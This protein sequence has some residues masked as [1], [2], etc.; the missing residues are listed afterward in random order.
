M[1][2]R[3]SILGDG[4]WGTALSIVLSDHGADVLLW[5]HDPDY[6]AEMEQSRRNPKFLPGVEIPD[7]VR[8]SSSLKDAVA[9][10]DMLF[11]VVPTPFL[12]SVLQRLKPHYTT[13]VP[14]V[15]ATKGIDTETLQRPTEIIRAILGPTPVAVV[16]GPS[17]A[18]EVSR[19]MPSTVVAAASDL[20]L[21]RRV[22]DLLA[23]ERFRVYTQRDVIG[24]ELGGALKNVIAI[25]GG[26]VDGLGFGDNTKAALLTRGIVEMSRL[27]EAMGAHRATFFGLSGIGDLITSCVSRHGR[28]RAVG[29]RLGRG[30]KLKNILKGMEMVAEGVKTSVAV[31]KVAERHG[32]E[33]PIC[34][35][36][37]SVLF[38]G[39]DPGNAV[40]DLMTRQLKDEV[41]W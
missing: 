21:A 11:S 29:E 7:S 32:V 10:C 22:Q 1:T 28:N 8:I 31:R 38:E 19:R 36:V 37:H 25:A 5:S 30:E 9:G 3:V 40:R 2:E 17:H 12:T 14:L 18:E 34:T 24:V 26:I 4:G 33:M 13:G 15:S 39:K 20:G 41:E 6:A 23:T 27:G 16:S 35:E